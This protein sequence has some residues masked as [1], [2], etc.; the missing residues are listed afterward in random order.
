[1]VNVTSMNLASK[2]T[3]KK[4]STQTSRIRKNGIIEG[5]VDERG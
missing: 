3:R 2:I 4:R 5:E 1:M